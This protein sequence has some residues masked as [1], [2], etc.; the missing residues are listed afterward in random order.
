M[1]EPALLADHI[2]QQT[3][4]ILAVWRASVNRVGDVPEAGKLA[5]DEF[6][7]HVPQILDRIADRLRGQS[8]ETAH[9][10]QEHGT[11]RWRQG[12]DIAEI[13][14]ELGHL[15]TALCRST[16]NFARDSGW[17]LTQLETAYQAIHTGLDD[18]TAE[19][20]RQYQEDSRRE[21][22]DALA[23]VKK[24][25]ASLEQAWYSAKLEQ[26][27]LQTVLAS[28][29]VAVWVSDAAGMIVGANPEAE[30]FLNTVETGSPGPESDRRPDQP[31]LSL[32]SKGPLFHIGDLTFDRAMRGETIKQ[33]ELVWVING[34]PRTCSVNAAPIM[35]DSAT[36]IGTVAVVIDIT[37]RKR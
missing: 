25:Q 29:P 7:D 24:R 28:L 21:T 18:V 15:R 6:I 4:E 33:E 17:D 34:A 31:G 3:D 5:Y 30:K 27:K 20:I 19:S 8:S 36:I 10:A 16:A 11:H 1:S 23:E 26:S 12:Y 14:K 22:Q 35:D 9:P 37:E 2:D 32:R 13:V